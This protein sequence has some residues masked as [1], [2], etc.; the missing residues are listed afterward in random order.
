LRIFAF[1]F[2]V[3]EFT[4]TIKLRLSALNYSGHKQTH[5]FI[6]YFNRMPVKVLK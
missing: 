6:N 4:E 1:G 3:S 2:A 5:E